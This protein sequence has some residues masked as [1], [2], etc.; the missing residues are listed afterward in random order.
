MCQTAL[1]TPSAPGL[2]VLASRFKSQ[3]PEKSGLTFT[4][5]DPN[6]D[7]NPFQR[8]IDARGRS[9]GL[10]PIGFSLDQAPR[11]GTRVAKRERLCGAPLASLHMK[12]QVRL[13][14]RTAVPT[15][16]NHFTLHGRLADLDESAVPRQM[17]VSCERTIRMQ[18]VDVVLLACPART[19]GEPLLDQEHR[20]ASSRQDRC[21]NR[22]QDIVGVLD[23]RSSRM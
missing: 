2:S 22:H 19:V 13:R 10:R 14:A 6:T 23:D 15:E 16:T 7:S 18:D 21:S 8:T 4:I 3:S 17:D 11:V 12:L 1:R 5:A 20:P 9:I